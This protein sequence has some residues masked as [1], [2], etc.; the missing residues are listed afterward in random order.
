MLGLASKSGNTFVTDAKIMD[1]ETKKLLGA[2]SSRGDNP[3]SL[4]RNQIDDLSQQIARATGFSAR[5]I[6][7]A[8]MR[9]RDVTTSSP[10]AYNYYL[11]G[12]EQL[13]TT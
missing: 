12:K 8:K 6:E 13:Y 4:F 9:V 11:K 10:E 7:A 5:K 1:V 3:E 2:A